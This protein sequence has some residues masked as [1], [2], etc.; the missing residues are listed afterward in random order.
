ME[1]REN[2]GWLL[3]YTSGKLDAA[4]RAQMEEHMQGCPAC[5]EFAGG[6]QAVWQALET[7]EPAAVSMDFDRRLYRRI[8]QQVSWWAR[9]TRSLNPLFRHAVPA[10]AAAGVVIMAGLMIIPPPAKPVAPVEQSAQVESLQPDQ[11]AHALDDMEM[12]R[13][14]N[15]LV[16][17]DN[18]D[19]KM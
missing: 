3:D 17:P 7:W 16:R 11:V 8:E 14:F 9:L 10:A 12:L 15:H 1:A 2:A 19:P 18:V 4:A 13:E 6:Q 5:R